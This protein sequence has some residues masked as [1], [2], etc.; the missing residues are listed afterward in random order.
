MF[1]SNIPF[2]QQTSVLTD[3]LYLSLEAAS[4]M[5]SSN[6]QHSGSLY[7]SFK[8]ITQESAAIT[9]HGQDRTVADIIMRVTS[10]PTIVE[11][12]VRTQI[13]GKELQLWRASGNGLSLLSFLYTLQSSNLSSVS[14]LQ[15]LLFQ[16]MADDQLRFPP[17]S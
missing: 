2:E 6:V 3:Q 15:G 16:S 4:T 13:G 7:A 14:R 5:Y 8:T 10:C 12:V 1:R 9:T 17:T 11:A